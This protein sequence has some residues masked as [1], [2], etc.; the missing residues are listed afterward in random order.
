MDLDNLRKRYSDDLVQ[1][2]S[3]LL[4]GASW[5]EVEELRSNISQL[6]LE[7]YNK[8]YSNPAEAS[9]RNQ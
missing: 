7:I 4:S 2:E 9:L 5:N 1:L 3:L 6:S 8:L